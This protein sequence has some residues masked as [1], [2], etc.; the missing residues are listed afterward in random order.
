MRCHIRTEESE[1]AAFPVSVWRVW[2]RRFHLVDSMA[3]CRVQV[4]SLMQLE[5]NKQTS[6]TRGICPPQTSSILKL[7][8]LISI[9]RHHVADGDW[10]ALTHQIELQ[11]QTISLSSCHQHITVERRRV[12]ALA[13]HQ[14]D[15]PTWKAGWRGAAGGGRGGSSFSST[16]R[17]APR[18]RWTTRP[19]GRHRYVFL[20]H[21]VC[22]IHFL[23]KC[24]SMLDC[25]NGLL[26]VACGSKGSGEEEDLDEEDSLSE[27]SGSELPDDLQEDSEQ[28]FGKSQPTTPSPSPPATPRPTRRRRKPRSPSFSDDENRPPS[29][30]VG[31]TTLH[32]YSLSF[33]VID[34]I[35]QLYY[36]IITAK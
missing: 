18:P 20:T 13:V 29:P 25:L 27:D 33:Q 11:F 32:I 7:D 21:H 30:K 1:G 12:N 24:L 15:T 23:V 28:S 4:D 22:F 9:N 8:G 6:S 10:W 19:L 36:L 2:M 31:G 5:G 3:R 14:G 35:V 16:R 17:D 34:L 26:V